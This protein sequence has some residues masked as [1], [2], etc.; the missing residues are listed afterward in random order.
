MVSETVEDNT[1]TSRTILKG[2]TTDSV[3]FVISDVAFT[4][5][6]TETLGAALISAGFSTVAQG[7]Q[8]SSSVSSAKFRG[9]ATDSDSLGGVTAANYL[10]ANDNDT[11]T[12]TL[13]ILN[14]TGLT[15]GAGSD[16]TLSLASD[17]FT[18]ANTTLNQS[19]I[20]I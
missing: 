5:S 6:S 10:R 7:I 12:G 4:P 2:V 19:L 15:I 9:T 3:V 20:H 1:G 18:I 8:L 14:D 17:N 13:G 11:T 16:A